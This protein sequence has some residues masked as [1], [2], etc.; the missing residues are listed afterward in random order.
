MSRRLR[1][2]EDDP[3]SPI[4]RTWYDIY[5]WYLDNQVR[6]H[7]YLYHN[8][9]VHH[10]IGSYQDELSRLFTELHPME[11]EHDAR[12]Y[13]TRLSQVHRQVGQVID[14]LEIREKMGII[15]PRFILE[16]A[17]GQMRSYLGMRS[18]DPSSIQGS[19][20]EV[21]L[22]FDDKLEGILALSAEQREALR[23]EAL[24]QI[25]TS[26]IPGY[27]ALLDALVHQHDLATSDAG[28]WKLPDGDAYYRYAL[29]TQTSTDLSPDEIHELGLTEVERIRAEMKSIFR[30]LGYPDDQPFGDS[31]ERAMQEGGSINQN[32]ATGRAQVLDEYKRLI[33][34]AEARA[35][36]AF[37]LKPQTGVLV[38][39]DRGYSGG[40]YYVP[41]SLDCSRPGAF[42][43]GVD[44]G[45]V[46][47]FGMPTLAYHEAVP[48]HHFQIGIAQDM[49]LPSFQQDIFFNAYVEGWALYA[50]RLAAE[51]GLYEN[52]P[53][54]NL[55]RLRL[56]LLR[57]VR[58][59]TDTGI[60]ARQWTREEARAYMIDALGDTR[61]RW[62]H[63]V[64]RYIVLPGQAT[65]YKIGM[66]KILELRQRAEQELGDG[67][68]LSQFHRA[69]LENGSMPLDILETV[70][71]HY[72]E[73]RTD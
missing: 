39:G 12:D 46:P 64:D 55:G 7:S 9:P 66:E 67:F 19:R 40:G 32:S 56:E 36:S 10:F 18:S 2:Y 72:I 57:A 21:Y 70:I 61:Q 37:D 13:V 29:R 65:G 4:Q 47:R 59:V 23:E 42:H 30:D 31:M 53:Y 15:P 71:E 3:L 49:N 22:V 1:T 5:E 11:T 25:E 24:N 52:D 44:D 50:E 68:D 62:P 38:V 58:L 48:G 60:H 45:S 16:M 6:G 27:V 73:L 69:V 14:G 41:G 33:Q 63:E 54:G 43:T 28:A 34:E 26:F 8:Y 35:E 17:I 51:L 20:L